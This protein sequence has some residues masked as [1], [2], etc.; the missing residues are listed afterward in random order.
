MK[1]IG[2][3]VTALVLLIQTAGVW[4]LDARHSARPLASHIILPHIPPRPSAPAGVEIT[5]VSV[6]VQIVEQN[7]VTVMDIHLRNPSNARLEAE[8]VIP[9]PDGAVV[10][11]LDFQGAAQEP[12][13][14]LLE[15]NEART[16][17]NSI[18][19]KVRDPALLE[20][21]SYNLIRSSV[22][23][24][25]PN[26]TQRI[27]IT[28]ETLLAAE[29]N[30]I[31]YVLPRSESIDYKA[32]WE[33][34]VMVAAKAPISTLYSPSHDV[35]TERAT[36]QRVR[37]IASTQ[38]LREPGPFRLSY[39][40][41]EG[42]VSA[43]LFAYPD[44]KVGGGYFLLL[45]GLPAKIGAKEAAAIRREVT[46]VLDRSGSMNGEK[47][48][49]AREA[50]LQVL[51]GLNDGEAFN[52]ITYNEGVES[53]ASQPVIKN[54]DTI[55]AA[56]AYVKGILPRGGTNIHD[57][58]LEALKQK[59]TAEMLPIVLFLT[60]GLPTIGQTAE[61]TIRD[62]AAKHNPHN[63]RVFTFGVGVDVNAP[64]LERI[65]NDTRATSS[66]VLP[67]ENVEVKVGQVFRRL[68]G[69]VVANPSLELQD[70][71]GAMAPGRV[72]D[73]QPNKLPD[74]FDGDQLVLLGQYVGDAPLN[75]VVKGQV[76]GQ[77][78]SYRF[79]FPLEKAT[80]RHSFVP[81]LWAS[82]R[83]NVLVDAIRQMG[84]DSNPSTAASAASDPKLKELVDEVVKLSKEFGIL[85][86]YTAFFAGEGTNLADNVRTLAI[87]TDNFTKRGWNDRSGAKGVNQAFNCNEGQQQKSLKYSNAFWDEKLNRVEV[88]GVQQIGD[89]AFYQ[90]GKRWIDSSVIDQAEKA[91]P[92]REI[93][94][95]SEE[96]L[97]LAQKL[98]AEGRQGCVSFRG[99]I[100]LQVDGKTVLVK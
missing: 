24:V 96:F 86:E 85:T 91:A 58:L 55:K 18:V 60:D 39:L 26:A 21:A 88:S 28:Y 94:F 30:R 74:L 54:D 9:V 20:F 10:R 33:V 51:S 37:V 99:E 68:N 19:A 14:Q 81:R 12:T 13:A 4:A 72:R 52:I 92:D 56:R 29:G 41:Q 45:A 89:R 53:F 97:A 61:K 1:R 34:S 42:A 3:S 75:F 64:L 43:S 90:R 87:A 36:E 98:A 48:D 59:P 46:L 65:A 49:Q 22:F 80:T 16:L 27:R 25:E 15:R 62:L 63:R 31:D 93:Q 44:P 6:A 8:T 40:L 71:A 17:Y 77:E 35:Q 69:P 73:L 70:A 38:A 66:F 7:A 32:P 83:I 67:A 100:L 47:M 79:S 23:P 50:L 84:A 95:G 78:K 82:R 5:K 76:F 57:A 2:L 11:G